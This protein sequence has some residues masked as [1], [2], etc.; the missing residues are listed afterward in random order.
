MTAPV[1]LTPKQKQF[2]AHACAFIG[3]GPPQHELAQL[4]TL[5]AMLLPEPVAEI[6]ARRAA[7]A[8]GPGPDDTLLTRLL[9]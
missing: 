5:A 1:H 8:G 9:Q 6:L 7:Q 3:S 4:L 2:L